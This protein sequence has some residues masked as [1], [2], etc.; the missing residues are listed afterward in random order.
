MLIIQH[1]QHS[2]LVPADNDI[3]GGGAE[4]FASVLHTTNFKITGLDLTGT[5]SILI[6]SPA[7]NCGWSKDC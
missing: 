5:G 7:F 1:S 6:T 3:T 2:A 4:A